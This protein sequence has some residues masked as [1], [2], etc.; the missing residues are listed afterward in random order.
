MQEDKAAL[1][2]AINEAA[3]KITHKRGGAADAASNAGSSLMKKANVNAN[4]ARDLVSHAGSRV[5]DM[6]DF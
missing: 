4:I 5:G 2:A 1:L 3:T 6:A